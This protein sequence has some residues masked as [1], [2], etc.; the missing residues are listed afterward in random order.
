MDA[1]RDGL[2]RSVPFHLERSAANDGFTLEGYAAVFDS[3]TRI[4]S[5]EG[6]FDEQIKRG[7]FKKT[8]AERSPVIQFDHGSHPMVGSIPIASVERVA[9]DDHGV[10][11]RARMFDNDLVKPVRDA[12]AGGAID[13]MSFRFSVVREDWEDR[14][15]DVPLRTIT[16]LRAPEMGPV[17]F[18]AYPATSVGV[19]SEVAQILDDPELREHLARALILRTSADD[20]AP[21][22]TSSADAATPPTPPAEPAPGMSPSARERALIL[23][24]VSP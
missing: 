6:N 2:T 17:V 11:V 7:A 9:E 23:L 12:I 21:T 10:F 24:G 4:D 1:P 5:W 3:V 19:R 15:D 13:G 14:S 8:L 20:A 22:G 16:E 18:P